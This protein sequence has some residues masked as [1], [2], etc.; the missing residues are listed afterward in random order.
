MCSSLVFFR[1][2]PPFS[3]PFFA[4]SPHSINPHSLPP[5]HFS[6]PPLYPIP[7]SNSLSLIPPRSLAPC[8]PSSIWAFQP[9]TSAF[10]PLICAHLASLSSLSADHSQACTRSSAQVRPHA[11]PIHYQF[12]QKLPQS[13]TRLAYQLPK[14]S[15]SCPFTLLLLPLSSITFEILSSPL[16]LRPVQ[17]Q[18]PLVPFFPPSILFSPLQFSP[19]LRNFANPCPT[20]WL[21]SVPS[22][23]LLSP[24]AYPPHCPPRASTHVA[25]SCSVASRAQPKRGR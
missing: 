22:G 19:K 25:R 18:I 24:F 10:Q 17:C 11:S 20:C 8:W 12:P 5:L 6:Y 16:Q 2:H 21:N 4:L 7:T 13:S 14:S 3:S 9:P 1:L 15:F 23:Q